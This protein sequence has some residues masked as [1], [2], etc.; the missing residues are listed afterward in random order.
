MCKYIKKPIGS[1]VL[2]LDWHPSNVLLANAPCN[3][4]RGIL[5]IHQVRG[6][7]AGT[8]TMGLQHTLWGADV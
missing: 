4:K 7:A 5:G 3:V 1:T 8:S 2:S 6:G